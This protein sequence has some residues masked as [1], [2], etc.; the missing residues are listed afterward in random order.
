MLS[1]RLW[2]QQ[3]L[4]F[5][6]LG[7]EMQSGS[8]T[9]LLSDEV[10]HLRPRRCF[11]QQPNSFKTGQGIFSRKQNTINNWHICFSAMQQ[12]KYTKKWHYNILLLTF[13]S[14]ISLTNIVSWTNIYIFY[15]VLSTTNGNRPESPPSKKKNPLSLGR[16]V[17]SR[18][19]PFSLLTLTVRGVWPIE[20]FIRS[21]HKRKHT[22]THSHTRVRACTVTS[23]PA[24]PVISRPKWSNVHQAR[25][26]EGPRQQ[27]DASALLLLSTWQ[28]KPLFVDQLAWRAI[29]PLPPILHVCFSIGCCM[30]LRAG[31][32]LII[33]L[34]V[35]CP[36][37]GWGEVGW[38]GLHSPL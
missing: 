38:G 37:V 14:K 5:S 27:S 4:G 36:G 26:S 25:C 8:K 29:M 23:Q 12:N 31:H 1:S 21:A 2:H 20:P 35:I 6:L 32:E 9:I 28:P 22:H 3:L 19:A 13:R 24:D 16:T 17:T 11:R 33:C 18:N 7:W 30:W 15:P 34:P 10:S